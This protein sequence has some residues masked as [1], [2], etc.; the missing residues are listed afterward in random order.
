MCYVLCGFMCMPSHKSTDNSY[1]STLISV[2]LKAN[3]QPRSV[4]RTIT[5]SS[6]QDGLD[7]V[8]STAFAVWLVRVP[9]STATP[10]SR[11]FGRR[12]KNTYFLF[13][14]ALQKVKRR[15]RR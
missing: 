1:E 15:N 14:R 11:T 4:I 10:L 13:F 5:A 8:A 9:A 12:K 3:R 7:M 6:E 2:N